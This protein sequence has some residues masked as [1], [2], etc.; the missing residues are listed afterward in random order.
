[1]VHPVSLRMLAAA[2]VTGGLLGPTSDTLLAQQTAAA[3]GTVTHVADGRGISGILVLVPALS[4]GRTTDARGAFLL[5]G[6]PAGRHEVVATLLGCLVARRWIEV[7]AGQRLTVP[8]ALSSPAFSLEGIVITA[9]SSD[10]PEAEMP[11]AIGRLDHPDQTRSART[12][13]SMIQG[14]VAGA[15]VIQ[16]SGQ[17]GQEPSVMLRGP[18]SIQGRQDPLVVV[19]GIITHGALSEIDLFDVEHVEILKGA[20]AAAGYGA[21]GGAGVIEITTKRGPGTVTTEGSDPESSR[22]PFCVAP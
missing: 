13:A 4:I 6:L 3:S 9:V 16:G 19:D 18:V 14:R 10:I 15:K 8:I 5:D 2:L 11:F 22:P 7:S 21:R 12:I 1:M 20:A 17:P